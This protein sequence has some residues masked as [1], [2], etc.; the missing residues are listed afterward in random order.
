M[1]KLGL[2]KLTFDG[3]RNLANK[4][5][6]SSPP[7]E[8]ILDPMS[9][10]IRLAILAYKP[11]GTKLSIHNNALYF[12]A[13]NYLQA[14]LR[15]GYSDNKEDLHN[16]HNPIA[17]A[18]DWYDLKIDYVANIFK[19]AKKGL[20]TIKDCYKGNNDSNLVCHSLN[21][22][23]KMIDLKLNQAKQSLHTPQPTR[24]N[25]AP[26]TAQSVNSVKTETSTYSEPR[27]T[28]NVSE[29][30]L[31]EADSSSHQQDSQQ[32]LEDAF[33]SLDTNIYNH[34]GITKLKN[35]WS[36]NEFRLIDNMF[37]IADEYKIKGETLSFILSSIN[38][39]VSGKDV[40][41]Q[42]LIVRLTTTL[43][44]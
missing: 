19:L 29:L 26:Q 23:S 6:F 41:V 38:R 1:D 25:S 44:N 14:P 16:L 28:I 3:T 42:D 4:I 13:P 35:Y 39:I 30:S 32:E 7:S 10:I 40:K 12:Q 27:T 36:Y 33:A 5:L 22:Y 18:L 2:I 21:Y 24:P 8:K 11:Q 20:N 34:T 17:K 15:W 43:T 9:T 37:K 31:I